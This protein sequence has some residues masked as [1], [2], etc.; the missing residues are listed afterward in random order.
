MRRFA[1]A[2]SAAKESGRG[3]PAQVPLAYQLAAI[4]DSSDDAIIS[5]SAEGLITS[6]NAGAERVYGYTAEEVL[7]RPIGLLVPDELAGE[8]QLILDRI[9]AGERIEHFETERVRKDG[10]RLWVS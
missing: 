6:W 9:L 8:D 3:A 4:V 1:G 10:S 5:K 2:R 7:G